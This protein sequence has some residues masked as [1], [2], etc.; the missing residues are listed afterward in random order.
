MA[1][2]AALLSASV[3]VATGM[4]LVAQPGASSLQR[5]MRT[6]RRWDSCRRFDRCRG[7]SCGGVRRSLGQ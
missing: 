6:L 3:A 4:V 7:V 1:S 2:S 5:Q